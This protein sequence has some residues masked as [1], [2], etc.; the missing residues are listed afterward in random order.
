MSLADAP[1]LCRLEDVEAPFLPRSFQPQELGQVEM[2]MLQGERTG[3]GAQ[4]RKLGQKKPQQIVLQKDD[5][6]S[7]DMD[8]FLQRQG[9][10][11]ALYQCQDMTNDGGEAQGRLQLQHL[12][13]AA[14]PGALGC[15]SPNSSPGKGLSSPLLFL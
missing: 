13:D 5:P 6:S 11:E 7:F 15:S 9:A 10:G 4:G 12:G 8:M 3:A 1:R 14:G 2:M